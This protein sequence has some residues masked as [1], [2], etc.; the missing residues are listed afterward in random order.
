[1]KRFSIFLLILGLLVGSSLW[2]IYQRRKSPGPTIEITAPF[3]R[4]DAEAY[5]PG[6]HLLQR[7]GMEME[8]GR[9]SIARMRLVN[10]SSETI[11]LLGYWEENPKTVEQVHHGEEWKETPDLSCW[12]G[13]VP[14]EVHPGAALDFETFITAKDD[15]IRVGI[16]F[17]DDPRGTL[18]SEPL[19]IVYPAESKEDFLFGRGP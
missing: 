18:W 19:E 17:Y 2:G 13:L 16:P 5:P 8:E 14:I 11:A 1:M 4:F 9:S 6:L 15:S 10:H 7:V 3:F 12:S